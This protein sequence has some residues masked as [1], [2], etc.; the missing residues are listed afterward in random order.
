MTGAVA[1]NAR[2][3][4]ADAGVRP[5]RTH[6]VAAHRRTNVPELPA[7]WVCRPRLLARLDDLSSHPIT[8][9]CAPAGHG[10]TGLVAEWCRRANSPAA[11]VSFDRNDTA[12][13]AW[14]HIDQAICAATGIVRGP[15]MEHGW[16]HAAT[17]LWNALG[18][19]GRPVVIVLD[20][21]DALGDANAQEMTR[22]ALEWLPGNVSAV[23]LSRVAPSHLPLARW[24]WQGRL[25]EVRAHALAFS[26]AEARTYLAGAWGHDIAVEVAD[27]WWQL[28]EGWPAGLRLVARRTRDAGP[29]HVGDRTWCDRRDAGSLVAAMLDRE[30]PA[31]ARFHWEISILETL[32]PQL[33]AAM[34]GS[35][36]AAD[37]LAALAAAGLIVQE[38]DGTYRHH[39]LLGDLLH[40]EL[41]HRPQHDL[42][43]LHLRAAI[44]LADHGMA[45]RA[46]E[47]AFAGGSQDVAV[48]LLHQRA[49]ELIAID[50]GATMRTL[51]RRM[52]DHG[53]AG[54]PQLRAIALDLALLEGDA[55]AVDD[56][57]VA[58]PP[59]GAAAHAAVTARA[60]MWRERL[61]GGQAAPLRD[62]GPAPSTPAAQ[63]RGV[64]AGWDGQHRLAERLL[65]HALAAV[66]DRG[67]LL[68][69]LVVLADLVW[70]RVTAGRLNQADL[71]LRRAQRLCAL[72]GLTGAP[73]Y[74]ELARA[75]MAR[76]RGRVDEAD[77]H[78]HRAAAAALRGRDLP[79]QLDVILMRARASQRRD[80]ARHA[81][82]ELT[83]FCAANRGAY[84]GPLA[85]ALSRADAGLRLRIGAVDEAATLVGHLLDRRDPESLPA[86]DRLLLARL[87][88][89]RRELSRVRALTGTVQPGTCGPRAAVAAAELEAEAARQA[90]DRHGMASAGR[91]ARQLAS[92]ETMLP[93][94]PGP[95][96]PVRDG[97]GIAPSPGFRRARHASGS[98]VRSEVVEGLTGR[99]LA[100]LELLGSSLPYKEMAGALG[101]SI[102]TVK[103]HLKSIY[104][105]LGV[106]SRADALSC[107]H[108]L[109]LTPSSGRHRHQAGQLGPVE[110]L[111]P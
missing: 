70:E 64:T 44:V 27:R 30:Q 95:P 86:A 77:V 1:T 54:A 51:L 49:A 42:S 6:V 107:A 38:L 23:L 99:E 60:A 31:L 16:H 102:N 19:D 9:V 87:W 57:L 74:V 65:R 83:D 98:A 13:H 79:L 2:T 106:R 14:S 97:A 53:L 82:R 89:G 101:I 45:H 41:H 104:R 93:V 71:L 7:H 17:S 69:E 21:V 36:V 61:R 91:R 48:R 88:L 63:L 3:R 111:S 18:E 56:L 32:T 73:P 105:K 20:D 96:P 108:D 5:R 55:A 11:W 12:D 76:D 24:R 33:C 10:K 92:A 85:R 46:V 78:L 39:R 28:T 103:S 110:G 40:S 81:L 62:G 84:G 90:G 22:Y 43:D 58:V 34:T 8:L 52:P 26:R 59:G 94:M 29:D 80:A 75:Q 67:D 35:P 66:V 25:A 15:R 109:R 100:V 50:G 68:G 4:S 37:E 72:L 47:H